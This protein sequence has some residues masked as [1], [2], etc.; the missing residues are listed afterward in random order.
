MTG[1]ALSARKVL[2]IFSRSIARV[3]GVYNQSPS[4]A[5]ICCESD[6]S[7][8]VDRSTVLFPANDGR[9]LRFKTNIVRPASLRLLSVSVRMDARVLR[10]V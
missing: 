5:F 10:T 6:R 7:V 4:V 1:L 8:G 9:V 3:A 2:F